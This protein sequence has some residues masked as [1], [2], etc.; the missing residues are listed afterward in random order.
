[1]LAAPCSSTAVYLHLS[2]LA[3]LRRPG[4]PPA[5][6]P[7]SRTAAPPQSRATPVWSWH[8]LAV[9][10]PLTHV[11]PP[12]NPPSHGAPLRPN[13]RCLILTL[14]SAFAFPPKPHP[15]I[16]PDELGH[17]EHLA[18]ALQSGGFAAFPALLSPPGLGPATHPGLLCRRLLLQVH[19][20]AKA[21]CRWPPMLRFA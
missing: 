8:L 7:V 20:E 4:T 5:H 15:P 12:H 10:M 18:R 13:C 16:T 6:P 19:L 17:D 3:P 9:A 11:I 14:L 1:M 21:A 2:T